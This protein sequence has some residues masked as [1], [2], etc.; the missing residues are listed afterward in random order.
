M[1]YL[2]SLVG[3]YNIFHDIYP[4]LAHRAKLGHTEYI[5]SM[6]HWPEPSPRGWE[7]MGAGS[8]ESFALSVE[9]WQHTWLS[10]SGSWLQKPLAMPRHASALWYNLTT[11]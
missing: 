1:L 8:K 6:V 2:C 10:V 9:D 5:D 7:T 11:G 4:Q 3:L